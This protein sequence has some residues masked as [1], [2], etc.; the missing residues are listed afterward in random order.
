MASVLGGGVDGEP[1]V[2]VKQQAEARAVP[3]SLMR[4]I[5]GLLAICGMVGRRREP[6]PCH[7]N[8]ERTPGKRRRGP[9]AFVPFLPYCRRRLADDLSWTR[10]SSE[11]DRPAR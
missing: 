5:G 9:H 10:S 8:G 11:R 1:A 7:P 4:L 3:E 2:T 6:D